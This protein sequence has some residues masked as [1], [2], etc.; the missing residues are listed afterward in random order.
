MQ[1]AAFIV[2]GLLEENPLVLIYWKDALEPVKSQLLPAL[3]ASLEDSKWAAGERRAITEFYRVFSIGLPD[4]LAPLQERLAKVNRQGLLGPEEAKGKANVGAALAALGDGEKVWPLLMHSPWP[5]LRSYLIERLGVSGIDPLTLKNRLEEEKET[6]IRRALILAVGGFP[7][8]RLPQMVPVLVKLYENDPDP[9][10]H[11]AAAWVLRSWKQGTELDNIDQRLATG[12]IEGGRGWYINKQRQTFTFVECPGYFVPGAEK[13]LQV[14]A[15]RIAMAATEVTVQQFLACKSEH[16]VDQTMPTTPD[17]PVNKVSWYDAAEYC[18]WLSK[19]NEIP[20]SQWCYK[21]NKDGLLDF[22]PDY[23]KLTGYR[24]PT[25]S[26]WEFACRAGAQT[27]WC[28]GEADDELV[29]KYAWWMGNAHVSGVRRCFPVGLLKPNDLGLF[30]MHGNLNEWCQES[31]EPQQGAFSPDVECGVRGGSFIS[32]F[33]DVG[34]DHR[35]V[36]GR[37]MRNVFAGVRPVKTVYPAGS[38]LKSE[39]K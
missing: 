20:E 39:S 19:Q 12:R 38:S 34:S 24:L 2:E 17:S 33:L 11:G 27:R 23:Q 28:F 37:E 6:S 18:N 32:S 30:D 8:D 25:E 29:G 26:E 31:I 14:P 13:G 7:P 21:R 1:C 16:E 15:H 10:V 36:L 4:A 22:V 35:F 9:G 5:T 3:A